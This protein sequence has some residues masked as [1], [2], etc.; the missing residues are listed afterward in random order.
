YGSGPDGRKTPWRA[1]TEAPIR[2]RRLRRCQALRSGTRMPS[3]ASKESSIS[4]VVVREVVVAVSAAMK[5][6][7]ATKGGNANST[8]VN[9]SRDSGPTF[10]VAAKKEPIFGGIC[11]IETVE[12][13]I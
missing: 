10:G 2:F 8:I 11:V 1:R 3:K 7:T 5:T 12:G 13:P 9:S 6:I 4:F